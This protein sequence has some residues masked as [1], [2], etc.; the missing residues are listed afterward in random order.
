MR[1]ENKLKIF[2]K[3]SIGYLKRLYKKS[4]SNIFDKNSPWIPG[5]FP[6]TGYVPSDSWTSVAYY[7]SAAYLRVKSLELG[8]SIKNSLLKKANIQ[9]VRIYVSGFNLYT[10]TNMK[11]MDPELDPSTWNYQYPLTKNY[12]I[13]VN[14]TF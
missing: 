7:P 9:N 8:Y 13:G 1:S 10:W 4:I 5:H 11:Y 6:A 2:K 3:P 12:N 14:I